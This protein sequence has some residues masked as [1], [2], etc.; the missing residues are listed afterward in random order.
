MTL[1][2]DI[3]ITP[4]EDVRQT[5]MTHLW[6]NMVRK[7][8]ANSRDAPPPNEDEYDSNDD[9]L[10]FMGSTSF[11]IT[12][13]PTPKITGETPEVKFPDLDDLRQQIQLADLENM[14]RLGSLGR[15][16][17]MDRDGEEDGE[18][19]VGEEEYERLEDWLDGDP[20]EEGG[21]EILPEE[22]AENAEHSL[23]RSEES[24][25]SLEMAQ[26]GEEGFEND[27]DD[28]AAFQSA[29]PR[30]APNQAPTLAL[31]PTP[32]LLHLQSVRVELAGV[33][34]EDER[35]VRAGREVAKLMRDL[36]M[37]MEDGFSVDEND[38]LSLTIN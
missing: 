17:M 1:S 20:G 21:F 6:P 5:L 31:D 35:R 27:F 28:F 13:D 2:C 24:G 23:T 25:G 11:P 12:F 9:D 37:G 14:D 18:F 33:G 7:P 22:L 34:D 4:L 10:D 38:L 8:L 19:G 3:A 30:F 32:L 36:G 29:P 16:D 15:L 26:T